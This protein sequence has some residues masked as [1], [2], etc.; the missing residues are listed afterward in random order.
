MTKIKKLFG[1]FHITWKAVIFFAIIAGVYTGLINQVPFLA[2]TSFRDI[3]VSYEVWMLF[4]VIIAANCE[5]PLESACKIF[6]FFLISQPLCFLV[7]VPWIGSLQAMSYLNLWMKQI[8]LTFPG[9]L[10]AYYVKKDNLVGAL[11]T[12]IAAGF[13]VF[14]LMQYAAMSYTNFPHH[15]LTVLFCLL[16]IICLIAFLIHKKSL[17]IMAAAFVVICAGIAGYFIYNI[18]NVLTYNLPD[19]YT[20]CSIAVNDGSYVIIDPETEYFTYYYKPLLTRENTLTF[21]NDQGD[22]ITYE[23]VKKNNSISIEQK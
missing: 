20:A 8:L 2:N 18:T 17:R 7:E 15:I 16:T 3:A 22:R 12:S 1:G 5:K 14:F 9:G 19:R 23:V 10:I 4:A 6:A 11:I 13:E 21:T